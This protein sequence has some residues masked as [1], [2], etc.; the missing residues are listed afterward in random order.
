MKSVAGDAIDLPSQRLHGGCRSDQR[1]GGGVSPWRPAGARPAPIEAGC[2]RS[3][4]RTRRH[5]RRCPAADNPIRRAASPARVPLR[6]PRQHRHLERR[7]QWTRSRRASHHDRSIG[8]HSPAGAPTARAPDGATFPRTLPAAR[9]CRS[10]P[11]I[12]RERAAS[13]SASPSLRSRRRTNAPPAVCFRIIPGH[14]HCGVSNSL[15]WPGRS[16]SNATKSSTNTP[17][18]LRHS[19][20]S[21]LAS[22]D[23]AGSIYPGPTG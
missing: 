16:N 2:D 18:N 10:G 22:R 19:Q 13:R 6:A 7:A 15:W 23:I 9:S 5:A 4:G 14:R 8:R 20:P 3:P 21:C 11:P 12:A 17:R 1:G